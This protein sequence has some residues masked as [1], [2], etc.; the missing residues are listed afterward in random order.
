MILASLQVISVGVKVILAYEKG[1]SANNKVILA[2]ENVKSVTEND[3]RHEFIT[4]TCKRT[5]I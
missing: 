1:I 5:D 3:N 4:S 2:S